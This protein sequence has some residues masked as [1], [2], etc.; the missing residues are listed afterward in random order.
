LAAGFGRRGELR[1]KW[2]RKRREEGDEGDGK[3]EGEGEI[4]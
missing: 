1:G 4:K 2:G 3:R